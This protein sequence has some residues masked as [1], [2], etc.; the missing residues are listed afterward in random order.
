[1]EHRAKIE[2]YQ[3]VC[4]EQEPEIVFEDVEAVDLATEVRLSL[5]RLGE[6]IRVVL[7]LKG[8]N[9]R[10][11]EA[12]ENQNGEV[13]EIIAE[14]ESNLDPYNLVVDS[15]SLVDCYSQTLEDFR[16]LR[17]VYGDRLFAYSID[18]DDIVLEFE[19]ENNYEN[20]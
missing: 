4:S 14:T 2:G 12:F 7:S 6:D 9:P 10:I 3:G 20:N 8:Y 13:L 18:G 1:M 17:L 15:V 5:K 11:V 19:K 16:I